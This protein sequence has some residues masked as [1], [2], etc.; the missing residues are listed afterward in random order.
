MKSF[1]FIQMHTFRDRI[2]KHGEYVWLLVEEDHTNRLKLGIYIVDFPSIMDSK[3]YKDDYYEVG[4]S[5]PGL[6]DAYF[7]HCDLENFKK[8]FK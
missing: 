3:K 6:D 2:P 5:C 7:L 1:D 8:K 4:G